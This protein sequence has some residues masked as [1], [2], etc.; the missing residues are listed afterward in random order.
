[1]AEVE[2]GQGLSR[3]ATRGLIPITETKTSL[4]T[5]KDHGNKT[6]SRARFEEDPENHQSGKIRC[7]AENKGNDR[8][9]LCSDENPASEKEANSGALVPSDD[10]PGLNVNP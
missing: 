8:D 3:I 6:H 2:R 7:T 1:M 10:S 9:R 5:G 4:E